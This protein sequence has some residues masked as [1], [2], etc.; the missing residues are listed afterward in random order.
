MYA[1]GLCIL[2][3]FWDRLGRREVGRMQ[4]T[5]QHGVFVSSRSQPGYSLGE[6]EMC[7]K[8][9]HPKH[10]RGTSDWTVMGLLS[11]VEEEFLEAKRVKALPLQ[12]R[13]ICRRKTGRGGRSWALTA[14]RSQDVPGFR[15]AVQFGWGWPWRMTNAGA[16][17]QL[18]AGRC[19]RAQRS[20]EY[21]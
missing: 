8:R 16:V 19:P 6:S 17:N 9:D 15:V 12:G 14:T 4:K 3:D 2:S 18:A 21:F 20:P 1:A 5:R 7:W 10:H 11:R 13:K